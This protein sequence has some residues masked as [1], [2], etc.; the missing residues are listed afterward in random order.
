MHDAC[1]PHLHGD[2][3]GDVGG[4]HLA[5]RRGLSQYVEVVVDCLD[6]KALIQLRDAGKKV[7]APVQA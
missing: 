3:L 4:I 7:Q 2:Q 5:G 1:C 6:A